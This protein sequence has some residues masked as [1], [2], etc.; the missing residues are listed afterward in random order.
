MQPMS[1]FF[2]TTY[3]KSSNRRF[4]AGA[5][6]NHHDMRS[7]LIARVRVYAEPNRLWIFLASAGNE[8]SPTASSMPFGTRHKD[9]K[10]DKATVR[11]PLS[12]INRFSRQ[13]KLDAATTSL[14]KDSRLGYLCD[15]GSHSSKRRPSCGRIA[16]QVCSWSIRP[17]ILHGSFHDGINSLVA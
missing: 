10:R 5:D 15:G 6:H 2:I 16:F 8:Y 7:R 3:P 13:L 11:R 1:L 17:A 9:A 14:G 4:P 12:P